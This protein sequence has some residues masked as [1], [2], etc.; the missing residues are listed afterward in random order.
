MI[1]IDVISTYAIL[2]FISIVI[3]TAMLKSVKRISTIIINSL[4]GGTVFIILNILGLGLP[5]NIISIIITALLGIPGVL[6]I[7]VYMLVMGAWR[8]KKIL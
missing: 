2:F 1:S 7:I 5:V 3:I 6:L 8:W 4:I